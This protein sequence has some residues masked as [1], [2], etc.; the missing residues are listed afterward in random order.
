LLLDHDFLKTSNDFLHSG[1]FQADICSRQTYACLYLPKFGG[2]QAAVLVLPFHLDA[3]T[4][5]P[6]GSNL[7]VVEEDT[8]GTRPQVFYG[9]D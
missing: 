5:E 6:S 7:S 2:L 4:H 3:I 8:S 9:L 1:E